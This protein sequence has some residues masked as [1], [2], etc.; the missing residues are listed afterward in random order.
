[1]PTVQRT[2][3]TPEQ[4]LMLK[5]KAPYH[6]LKLN[7]GF[8]VVHSV[9][10]SFS[11]Q[12]YLMSKCMVI[13]FYDGDDDNADNDDD[14]DDDDDDGDNDEFLVLCRCQAVFMKTTCKSDLTNTILTR[15]IFRPYQK[16]TE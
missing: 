10:W 7:L 2:G 16:C 1:M 12:I 6:C 4:I 14:D 8:C 5:R 9:Y 3:W 13:L 15:S 11:R